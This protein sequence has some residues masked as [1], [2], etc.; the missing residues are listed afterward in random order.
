M[1][2]EI[3]FLMLLSQLVV[4]NQDANAQIDGAAK[5]DQIDSTIYTK[6]EDAPQF[7]G[8]PFAMVLYMKK[9]TQYP[10]FARENNISG[11][12][13]VRFVIEQ[14]G[15]IS[16]IEQVGYVTQGGSDSMSDYGMVDSA[17]KMIQGMPNWQPGK[18]KGIPVRSQV[19][20]P[21]IFKLN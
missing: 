10:E 4:L 9:N 14:D 20:I 3:L 7:V 1:K 11:R 17:I 8:G 15:S 13:M 6:V 16:N 5:G 21:V 18:Q 2:K 19:V 12:V